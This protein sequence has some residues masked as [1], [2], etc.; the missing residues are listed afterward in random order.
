MDDQNGYA[1]VRVY[2]SIQLPLLQA[3]ADADGELRIQEAIARL[4]VFLPDLTEQDK[5]RRLPS[6]IWGYFQWQ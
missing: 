1:S 3:I 5:Q 4:E 6:V 2:D